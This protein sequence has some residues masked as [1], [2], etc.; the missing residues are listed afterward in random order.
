MSSSNRLSC[1]RFII[2]GYFFL[3]YIPTKSFIS[4][5]SLFSPLKQTES[6]T[7]TRKR[8]QRGFSKENQQQTQKKHF[9]Q[10]AINTINRLIYH[11]LKHDEWNFLCIVKKSNN[12]KHKIYLTHSIAKTIKQYL[13]AMVVCGV[14]K[15]FILAG[16]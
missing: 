6:T 9:V 3:C 4:N 15:K 10:S 16:K 8:R 11:H 12:K 2:K 13:T 7:K 5:I 1:Q 14:F